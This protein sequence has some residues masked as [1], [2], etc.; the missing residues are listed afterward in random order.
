MTT[1]KNEE[2]IIVT[3]SLTYIF[4]SLKLMI[5]CYKLILVRIKSSLGF[6]FVQRE[7]RNIC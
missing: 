6:F 1:P 5:G 2:Q 7:K 4:S 3:Y